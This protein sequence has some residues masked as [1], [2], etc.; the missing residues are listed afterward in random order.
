MHVACFSLAVFA[1][2]QVL[3]FMEGQNE[4]DKEIQKLQERATKTKLE[5]ES[6][7]K[8]AEMTT[9]EAKPDCTSEEKQADTQSSTTNKYVAVHTLA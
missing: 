7:E 2:L 6:S 5:N 3:Q 4:V 9:A 1:V 8:L